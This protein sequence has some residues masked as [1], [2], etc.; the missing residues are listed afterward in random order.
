MRYVDY[1]V[2]PRIREDEEWTVTLPEGVSWG[3]FVEFS[4][5][6]PWAIIGC[7]MYSDELYLGE[8][9]PGNLHPVSPELQALLWSGEQYPPAPALARDQLW[10]RHRE[11]LR[12]GLPL[13]SHVFQ[14]ELATLLQRHLDSQPTAHYLLAKCVHESLGHNEEGGYYWLV[15]FERQENRTWWV[16]DDYF[17]YQSGT[18][19]FDVTRE[20]L[21]KLPD[22]RAPEP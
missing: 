14:R 15:G 3:L 6:S 10:R 9:L 16:S 5:Q 17:V 22:P 8:P 7:D 18:H 13:D 21:D 1:F 20:Q 12:A 19:A 11:L 4:D 2:A